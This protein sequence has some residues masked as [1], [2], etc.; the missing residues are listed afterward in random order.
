MLEGFD[1]AHLKDWIREKKIL[2]ISGSTRSQSTNLHL[3]NLIANLV[4]EEWDVEIYRELNE[5]PHFNPDLDT[6][7]VPA[8]VACHRG[9]IREADGVII[10]TPEY[11]FS[12][13]GALKNALEW[14]VSTMVFR[15]SPLYWSRLRGWAKKP[16]SLAADHE[17]YICWGRRAHHPVHPQAIQEERPVC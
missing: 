11:V 13:P 17:D 10:C 3:L 15:R 14:T 2:A 4:V 9:K 12:L 6:H 16:R 1:L 8:V 7:E 5:L